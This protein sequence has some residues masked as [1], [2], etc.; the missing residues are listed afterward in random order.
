[1][2]IFTHCVHFCSFKISTNIQSNNKKHTNKKNRQKYI[3]VQN[4]L[5]IK[6]F[7][8]RY[9]AS[10]GLKSTLVLQ[11]RINFCRVVNCVARTRQRERETHV[12]IGKKICCTPRGS[13]RIVRDSFER[14]WMDYQWRATIVPEFCDEREIES[15]ASEL[16]LNFP[17]VGREQKRAC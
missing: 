13:S 4:C 16:K 6:E 17:C 7:Q 3:Y 2:D 9:T 15:D 12:E 8:E 5:E 1:M 14:T 11:L 10:R